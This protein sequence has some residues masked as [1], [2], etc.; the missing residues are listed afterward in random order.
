MSR[1]QELA[2]RAAGAAVGAVLLAG[3]AGAPPQA[4]PEP[5][6]REPLP[7]LTVDQGDA[8][9]N[10]VAET[11]AAADAAL[12]EEALARRAAAPARD[13]RA[14][15]YTLAERSDGERRPSP[16]TTEDQVLVV[17][18]T[19]GWPRTVMAV[20]QPPEGSNAPLL[21]VL[22]QSGPR[23]L[24]KLTSW[25]RLFPG[26]QTPEMAGP[27]S[28]SAQLSGDAEG[29][30]ASPSET[31]ARYGDL[32]AKGGESDHAEF[33]APD[34]YVRQQREAVEANRSSLQG[35]ADVRLTAAGQ[36]EGV[37]A[38]ETADEGALVVGLVETSIDYVKT[39]AGSTLSLGG[40]IGDWL[41]DGDVPS[42]ANVRHASM[43]AF[44][45]PPAGAGETVTVL[46]AERVLTS[47]GKA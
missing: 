26:V 12:D 10:A 34:P 27:E 6:P 20:T 23:D 35:I 3:C 21:V 7:A 4:D 29:F 15:Q 22:E 8:V 47:A 37:V 42:V 28:G 17:G 24:Y 16:L 5:E 9:L 43:V 18:A 1:R 40:E 11:V 2:R 14:A 13:L 32:L 25:V 33:F 46:G 31:V 45:V 19:E 30:L 39:L 41:G 38:L 44:Y 36:R